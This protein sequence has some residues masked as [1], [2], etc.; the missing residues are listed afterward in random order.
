MCSRELCF[1]DA[2]RSVAALVGVTIVYETHSISEDN[3]RGVATG[4]LPGRLSDRGRV[5]AH[6]LGER[7]RNDGVKV[8]FTSDLARAVENG[9]ARIRRVWYSDPSGSAATRVQLLAHPDR[10]SGGSLA[11]DRRK[12]SG[13]H[14]SHDW[15]RSD[16]LAGGSGRSIDVSRVR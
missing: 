5:L 6:E 13:S 16:L 12:V 2:I 7:R 1:A 11:Q 15:S 4:W 3:E 9:R 14:R 10:S 8:V